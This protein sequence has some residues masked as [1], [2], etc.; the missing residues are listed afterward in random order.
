MPGFNDRPKI[1]DADT[2]LKEIRFFNQAKFG[3]M[4]DYKKMTN[5]LKFL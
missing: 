2:I 5:L 1:K 4:S 3:A